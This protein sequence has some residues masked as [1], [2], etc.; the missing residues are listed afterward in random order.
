VALDSGGSSGAGGQQPGSARGSRAAGPKCRR[1]REAVVERVVGSQGERVAAAHR[2]S[3]HRVNSPGERVA[4]VHRGS[5]HRVN[6]P[7]G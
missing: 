3:G 5:G 7:G 6:L 4:A 2:G 1:A